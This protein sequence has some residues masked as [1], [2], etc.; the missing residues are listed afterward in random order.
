MHIGQ[1][2]RHYLNSGYRVVAVEANPDLVE[3]NKEKFKKYI[4]KGQLRII[5]AG[6]SSQHD[7]IPFY[8]NLR[9]TEWS[10]FDKNLGTRHHTPFE[11]IQVKCIK[12]EEL[13]RQFGVPFYL[14]VDIEGHDYL[15]IN[16]LDEKRGLPTYVS[17][18]AGNINLLN[19]LYA[20][21]Y[22]KF[23]MI[24]Q[25][26]N[27][28]PINIQKENKNWFPYYLQIKNGVQSRVQKFIRCKYPYSSSG[29]FGEATKGQW[30]SYDE[31]AANY[32]A[33]FGADGLHGLH[34]KSWFDFHAK[35]ED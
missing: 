11:I 3:Q 22:K 1:D 14:K 25:A 32:H 2:T 35:M 5:H 34:D 21:G 30:F 17:C 31:I 20:K 9:T 19:T 15:C 33:F 23:K 18:E 29:P 26:D 8:K 10:S 28:K 12:A 4:L 16:A 6:I 13:F 27:F 24:N 7:T